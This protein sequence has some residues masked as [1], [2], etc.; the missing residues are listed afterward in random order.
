MKPIPYNTMLEVPPNEIPEKVPQPEPSPQFMT[1][2]SNA[3]DKAMTDEAANK[4]L[5]KGPFVENCV[6]D[7]ELT[8]SFDLVDGHKMSYMS[9]YQALVG[10]IIDDPSIPSTSALKKEAN[11]AYATTTL[12]PTCGEGCGAHGVCTSAAC[13]CNSGWGGAH[14][15]LELKSK[16]PV[17][18]GDLIVIGNRPVSVSEDP[19][20]ERHHEITAESEN[21]EEASSEE[22]ADD[23]GDWG[24]WSDDGGDWS[25]DGGDWGDDGGD[26]SDDGGD[27]SDDGGD[28]SDDGGDWSGDGGDGD[29]NGD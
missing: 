22:A 26:W 5:D 19:A 7:C 27:W 25:D 16:G 8:L 3:C 17:T 15:E 23:S 14:C 4:I 9:R 10:S 2:C 12:S 29:E 6:S 18:T 24:D 11:E 21:P 20:Q 13:Q 28:W 1:S